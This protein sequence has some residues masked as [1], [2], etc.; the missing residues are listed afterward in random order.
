MNE[1]VVALAA[2]V[3]VVLGQEATA[4]KSNEIT[5]IPLWLQTLVIKGAI[6]TIDAAGTH[7]PIAQVIHQDKEPDYVLA[8]KDNQ[9]LLAESIREFFATGQANHWANVRHDY[10]E[11]VEKDHRRIEVRRYYGF[12][13]LNCLAEPE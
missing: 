10:Y 2:G 11:T 5:A 13:H 3:G 9:P 7:A 8:V 4:E 1:M 6:V 12:G